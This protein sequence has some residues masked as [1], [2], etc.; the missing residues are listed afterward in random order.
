MPLLPSSARGTMTVMRADAAH[1]SPVIGLAVGSNLLRRMYDL[2]PSVRLAEGARVHY[3]IQE[4]TEIYRAS[5]SGTLLRECFHR[6][7]PDEPLRP[8]TNRSLPA[9]HL[10]ASLAG[11]VLGLAWRRPSAELLSSSLRRAR[12]SETGFDIP[13]LARE[14]GVTIARFE[15]LVHQVSPESISCLLPAC[16]FMWHLIHLTS[17][18]GLCH[19]LL[20]VGY[21]R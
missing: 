19:I 18:P 16:L 15:K 4:R 2:E 3:G 8:T 13:K 1:L 11:H 6:N 14:T 17:H 7:H 10:S 12:C 9:A 21:R 20:G 5:S